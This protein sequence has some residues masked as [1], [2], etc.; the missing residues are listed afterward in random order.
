MAGM[1][2]DGIGM[3]IGSTRLV[4][5]A[6]R[7]VAAV[8]RTGWSGSETE[9]EARAG[10]LGGDRMGRSFRESFDS[11]AEQV[12]VDVDLLIGKVERRADTGHLFVD[13][14]ELTKAETER[15]IRDVPQPGRP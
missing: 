10:Q 13:R 4:M 15:V 14:Y 11:V 5:D 12:A 2:G 6:L 7:Q 9:I 3:D 8:F 1:N